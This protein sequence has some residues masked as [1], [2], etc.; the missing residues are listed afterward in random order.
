MSRI[1]IVI[2][3]YHRHKPID[4]YYISLYKWLSTMK[5]FIHGYNKGSTLTRV[6]EKIRKLPEHW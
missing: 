5:P 2:L 4:L 6:T 1:V 3:I